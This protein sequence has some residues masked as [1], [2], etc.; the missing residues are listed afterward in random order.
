M[1]AHYTPQHLIPKIKQHLPKKFKNIL[2]PSVGDGALLEAISNSCGNDRSVLAFDISEQATASIRERFEAKF[3]SISIHNRCFI[4]WYNCAEFKP[5]FD[6]ILTNPPFSAKRNT[7]IDFEGRKAPIEIAFL[8]SCVNL[9]DHNGTLIAILPKSIVSG[10]QQCSVNIREYLFLY[11]DVKYCYELTEYEFPS[12]EGQFYLLIA[13]KR[14]Q[15][16]SVSIRSFE[17]REL[18]VSV[19]DLRSSLYRIDYS[20]VNSRKVIQKIHSNPSYR[21]NI[22]GDISTI[23]RG[24]VEP[25][26]NKSAIIHSTTYCSSWNVSTP[27]IFNKHDQQVYATNGDILVK[28]VGRGCLKSFGI[29]SIRRKQLASDCIL[30]I[31]PNADIDSYQLLFSL[32][33]LYSGSVGTSYLQRGTGAKYITADD[34][35]RVPIIL[36][37]FSIYSAEFLAWRNLEKLERI[38]KMEEIEDAISKIIFGPVFE[39]GFTEAAISHISR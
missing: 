21:E 38:D 24:S 23:Y 35:S 34:L 25:P 26:Y 33:V 8:K 30:I 27:T 6:L 16:G 31:R 7:W 1:K 12:I 5:S 13:Q 14:K 3:D 17:K 10:S 28:R 18:V 4:D 11:L 2:E 22:L 15:S 20:Y 37:L 32:R 9:L 29:L 19:S 39:D 36:N